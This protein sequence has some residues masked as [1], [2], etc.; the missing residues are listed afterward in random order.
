MWDWGLVGVGGCL[1]P[2]AC[3]G[4]FIVHHHTCETGTLG[5]IL[6]VQQ[7]SHLEFNKHFCCHTLNHLSSF[8]LYVRSNIYSQT[9]Y[10]R[11]CCLGVAEISYSGSKDVWMQLADEVTNIMNS[12]AVL[13]A[14]GNNWQAWAGGGFP[15]RVLVGPEDPGVMDTWAALLEWSRPALRG[16]AQ[17]CNRSGLES[18]TR[19]CNYL[20]GIK[21]DC[22]CR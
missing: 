12:Q 7:C 13:I 6:T 14:T 17:S 16:L 4:S 10:I 1:P 20:D 8:L 19:T 9:L 11:K 18:L 2:S 5:Q 22:C 3:K 21:V 15:L